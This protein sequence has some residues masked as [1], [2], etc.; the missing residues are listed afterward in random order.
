MEGTMAIIAEWRKVRRTRITAMALFAAVIAIALVGCG[1]TQSGTAS[2]GPIATAA[3]STTKAPVTVT[4]TAKPAPAKTTPTA[5]VAEPAQ[6]PVVIVPAPPTTVYQPPTTAY[7]PAPAPAPTNGFLTQDPS[8]LNGNSTKYIIQGTYATAESTI[9][10]W[11]PQ[12]SA[13]HTGLGAMQE[14]TKFKLAG[15]SDLI[16]VW[17]ADYTSFKYPDYYVIFAPQTFSTAAGANAWCDSQG[18]ASGDC[19]AKRLS[20]TDRPEGNNVD[21]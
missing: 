6:P 19:L 20:H 16:M 12:L 3:Q 11:I 7:Q 5:T 9:G 21:R 1:S 8:S 2:A 13:D 14:F 17:S 18:F 15:Y 4:K 10:Y